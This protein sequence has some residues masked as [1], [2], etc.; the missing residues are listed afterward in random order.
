VNA[1]RVLLVVAIIA[2]CV[3][4]DQA[5]KAVG[6]RLL[7]GHAPIS[8][9]GGFVR[10]GYVQNAGA[11]LSLGAKLS[12]GLRTGLFVGAAG[13]GLVVA[14]ALAL[15]TRRD[16]TL[17]VALA[18]FVGGGVGNV[19]DRVLNEGRVHDFVSI[20]FG[21]LRTGVFNLADVAITAAAVIL[22]VQQFTARGTGTDQG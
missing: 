19:I 16:R 7:A 13:I 5:T 15:S 3:G 12:P 8:L 14:A 2:G 6:R 22:V 10:I 4:A 20:G 11:L 21:W 18:L 9:A 17:A 1:R